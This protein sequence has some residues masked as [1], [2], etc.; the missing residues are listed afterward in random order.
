MTPHGTPRFLHVANGTATTRLI[1]AA[2]IPGILSIWADVLYEGPVPANLTDAELLEVRARFLSDGVDDVEP[3]GSHP[4]LDPVNDLRRWRAAIECSDAYDELILWFE[5]DLFDQLNL[6]QVLSWIHDRVPSEKTVSLVMIGSFAGR[7]RFKGL[8]ELEPD[9]I[10]SL[11]DRRQR[12][13]R[14]QYELAAAAWQA[15]RAPAPDAL[16]DIRRRDTSALP[17]LAAA[18]MRFLQEYPWTHDGL[19]RTERRLLS[20]AR[21]GRISLISAFPRMHD[22]EDAYYV[23]DGSLASTATDLARSSPPLLILS[24]PAGAG[25]D[26]LR[27]SVALTETGR[28]VLAGE[29][30]RI[31]ACGLDRWLGGVHLQSGSTMWRWDDTRQRVI[32]S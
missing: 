24:E 5:H 22:D 16:D 6:I 3:G 11:L 20:L 28:A 26:L 14:F 21:E 23:T 8:G 4:S 1:E 7:P 12:V 2:R 29:Q 9:E 32:A 10:A 31:I 25:A 19:S 13:S 27:G 17:Y 18:I 15:F 30:D